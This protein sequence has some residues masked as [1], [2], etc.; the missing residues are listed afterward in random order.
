M[1]YTN[2][3]EYKNDLAVLNIKLYLQMSSQVSPFSRRDYTDVHRV[4]WNVYLF[5]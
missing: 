2:L 4:I 5:V 3:N 1:N